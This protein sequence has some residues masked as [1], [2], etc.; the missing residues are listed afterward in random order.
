MKLANLVILRS[1]DCR[2]WKPVLPKDVPAWLKEPETVGRLVA[3]E[4]ARR[5]KG[6]TWYRAEQGPKPQVLLAET[7]LALA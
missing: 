7:R 3:G 2:R 4:M 6:K 5:R 1:T